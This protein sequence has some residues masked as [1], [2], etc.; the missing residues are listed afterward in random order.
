MSNKKSLKE[1][2]TDAVLEQL[3]EKAIDKNTSSDELLFKWWFSGRQEGLR[4]TE[5]GDMNFRQ[6]EIEFYQS[7]FNMRDGTS[8]HAYMLEL[9][10]K[11]KCPYYIGVS[12]EDKKKKPYIRLYDSK[13]AM[14]V[15]LYGT[16][17]E[18]LDSIKV[19]K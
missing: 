3:P 1:I 19:K 6:A 10:K 2:I 16:L 11:M 12:K 17:T 18:Y 9:N 4:L 5:W 15:G 13:I 7:D 8:H 14:M